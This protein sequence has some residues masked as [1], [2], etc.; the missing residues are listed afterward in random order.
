MAHGGPRALGV[1]VVEFRSDRPQ[2]TLLELAGLPLPP[3][4]KLF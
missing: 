2:L 4:M 1:G 3:G